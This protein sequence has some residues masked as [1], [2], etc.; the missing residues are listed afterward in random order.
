MFSDEVEKHKLKVK[1]FNAIEDNNPAISFCRSQIAILKEFI[2]S[3]HESILILE[4]DVEFKN[5]NILPQVLNELPKDWQML[6]LGSNAKPYPDFIPAVYFS[7]HLR[8][9]KSAFC[10]HAIAYKKEIAKWIVENYEYKDGQL[11][12]T[13]LDLV[14]LKKFDVYHTVPFLATQKPVFSSL[15]NRQVN[16]NDV[17]QAS[18]DYLTTI[19]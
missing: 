7:E 2:E 6:Y 9:V 16:Y 19:K 17:W 4:D 14:V 10:T 15:W 5:L 11:Y 12:D 13:W 1:A 3:D 8:V 18:E